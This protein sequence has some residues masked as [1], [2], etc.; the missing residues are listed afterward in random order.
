MDGVAFTLNLTSIPRA[1]L[2]NLAEDERFRELDKSEAYFRATQDA[3]KKYDWSGN[4]LGYDQPIR[5]GWTVP[6]SQRRPTSRYDLAKVIV[7]RLTSMVFGEGKF[8]ELR[9]EGDTE[10]EEYVRALSKEARLPVRLAEA[11]SYGG[12]EGTACLSFGFVDGA[13]RVRVHNPKHVSVLRWKDRDEFVVGAAMKAFAYPRNVYNNETRRFERKWFWTVTFWDELQEIIWRDIPEWIANE[14]DWQTKWPRDFQNVHAYGFAP[15]YWIQNKPDSSDT[16]GESDYI[17]L[18]STFDDIN[19]LMSATTKGTVANVD[20]TLVIKEDPAT[21]TGQ[22]FKGSGNAIFAKGGA[23]YLELKGTAVEAAERQADHLRQACL[24][25]A[26]VV[27]AD[28]EEL[29]G[30]AQSAKA[31]EILYQPMLANCDTLRDQYG[32]F[33]IKRILVDM[34]K[35]ARRFLTT[36]PTVATDGTLVQ[37]KIL[38]PPK[39]ETD[40]E[41]G[42]VTV[43]E[44]TP[45]TSERVTLN[46]RP[47]FS[48]TWKDIVDATTGMKNANGGKPTVSHR[49]SVQA[50]APLI[51]VEDIDEEMK[52]IEEEAEADMERQQEAFESQVE[53]ESMFAEPKGGKGE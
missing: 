5:P 53:T 12:A 31:L 6:M 29:S 21:N 51:G 22:V 46:W 42:T 15:L 36:A 23:E 1:P 20:P 7:N 8:P 19:R 18:E 17:G 2:R 30:A 50:I 49:S 39:I 16:D 38:L 47:Y 34:L 3:H 52:R 35:V 25:V 14:P 27:L 40:E 32:E 37:S 4:L 13:P 28:P 33:G 24:D 45:G 44:L 11:R 9:V 48:P 10:A 41:S 43:R 26:G